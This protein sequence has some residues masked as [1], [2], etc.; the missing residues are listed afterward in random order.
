MDGLASS[1][2]VAF[3]SGRGGEGCLQVIRQE[4]SWSRWSHGQKAEICWQESSH[5]VEIV[6]GS[7]KLIRKISLLDIIL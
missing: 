3:Y 4:N 5:V 7:K 1:V 2:D 6:E